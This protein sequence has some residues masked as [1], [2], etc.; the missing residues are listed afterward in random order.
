MNLVLLV[1]ICSQVLFSISDLLARAYMP[2]YG[3]G[4]AAFTTGWFAAYFLIRII[5]MFGQLYVFTSVELGKTLA[6]FGA[7]SIVLANILGLLVLKEVLPP[8]TYIA[9][10]LAVI[11]FLILAFH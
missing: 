11:A 8:A 2:K 5:A 4:L 1:L 9:V 6:L 7:V 3:F 10:V